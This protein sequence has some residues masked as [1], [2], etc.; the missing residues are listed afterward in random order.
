M[1]GLALALALAAAASPGT[2]G[3]RTRLPPPPL[4]LFRVAWQHPFVGFLPME[5]NPLEEGGVGVDPVSGMAVCGTRD[6]WLHSV[7]KDGSLA[8]E[9]K[10][11]NGFAAPPLVD[12]DTIYAAG[13]DGRVYA[14]ALAD[15][16]LRWKYE[17]GEELGG[18]PVLAG[19]TLFV[20]SLDDTLFALDARTGAWKWHSRRETRGIDR[21]YTIR[22][23]ATPVVMGDT[24]YAAYSDGFVVALELATGQIRWE[25]Q[26]APAGDYVD[27]DGLWADGKRVYAGAYSGAV[28]AVDAVTGLPAWTYRAPGVTRV[29]GSGG[30]VFGVS[31]TQL[32]AVTADQG[33][34]V[35]SAPLVGSPGQ[36]PTMAGRWL[37]VPAGDGGLRFVEPATGR[38]LRTFNA[39][40]G[41][42]GEPAVRG[43]RVYVLSNQGVLYALDLQ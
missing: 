18:R 20:M 11:A 13:G 2:D 19:G 32:V 16:A 9:F 1:G 14:L 21:G 7:R 41:V 8:W 28:V 39:G 4:D 30:L 33:T 34:L 10:A 23:T 24:V 31:P 36:A 26:V 6:G 38:T 27:V 17:A 37:L 42:S 29:L 35:W 5:V 40:S 3:L 12:G 15:G 43:N 25:A 22:G